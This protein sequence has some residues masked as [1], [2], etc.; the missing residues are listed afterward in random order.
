[1]CFVYLDDLKVDRSADTKDFDTKEFQLKMANLGKILSHDA[2]KFALACKPPRKPVD[3][4]RMVSEISNT[5]Y[6]LVGF[7]NTIPKEKGQGYRDAYK[8]SASDL[9]L[10][11]ISLCSSFMDK[12]NEEET[13]KKLVFMVPTAALWDHC[14]EMTHLPKDNK[15]AV[16]GAWKS[17]QETLK[18]AQS[19]VH[20]I[21][22]GEDI[23][24]GF[25]DE[26]E[27]EDKTEALDEEELEMAKTCSKLVDMSMFVT[28]KI[29]RRCVRENQNPPVEWLDL[30]YNK[31]KKLVDETDVLV[32]Q[33]YDEE[34][35]TMKKEVEKYIKL[36]G[37]LVKTAKEQATPEH[38]KWFEICENKYATM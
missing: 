13:K 34:V 19:E 15:E 30:I 16:L 12:K 10:G 7:Y 29:E 6:R 26:E 38:A 17:I 27:E 1:M 4:I 28:Q 8:S 2:T 35:E 9:L 33:L 36:A 32:S 14:N 37:D 11:V 25:D 18:D 21:A 23:S 22:S 31:A 5:I 24:G 20:D 3:A